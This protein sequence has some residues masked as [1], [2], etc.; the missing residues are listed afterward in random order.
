MGLHT[1]IA[2]PRGR[3]RRVSSWSIENPERTEPMSKRLLARHGEFFAPHHQDNCFD[4]R[5]RLEVV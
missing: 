3:S 2:Q 5:Q 4:A 1:G